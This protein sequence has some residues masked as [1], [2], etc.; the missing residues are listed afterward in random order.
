L[1]YIAAEH[2]G[3]ASRHLD[4]WLAFG[5]AT[6]CGVLAKGPAP[7]AFLAPL[8]IDMVRRRGLVAGLARPGPWIA[9]GA[10]LAV[11]APWY[12]TIIRELPGAATYFWENQVSERLFTATLHRNEHWFDG[13]LVYLPV[14]GL[15]LMPWAAGWPGVW[16]HEGRPGFRRLV[17]IAR[18]DP[19]AG[20]LALWIVLSTT[21]LMLAR[22]RLPL[23]ALPLAVPLAIAAGW[24]LARGARMSPRVVA[25][26]CAGFIVIK[27]AAAYVPVWHD[28]RAFAR[29]LGAL[30]GRDPVEVVC[31]DTKRNALPF[32]G[33]PE[34]MSVATSPNPY[35][36]Y[37]HLQSL[38]EALDEIESEGTRHI[39]VVPGYSVAPLTQILDNRKLRCTPVG[40]IDRNEVLICGP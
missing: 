18:R 5:V 3:D 24:A 10:A 40:P 23:Y 28:T 37:S 21:V 9:V 17:S 12:V 1:A 38:T 39:V 34:V 13:L 6:G 22:S 30:V 26:C 2:D 4:A 31:V 11:G 7:L 14:L 33:F 8:A 29:R 27:F 16:H 15:G 35:P 36:F 25:A 32:Y 19:R 20:L